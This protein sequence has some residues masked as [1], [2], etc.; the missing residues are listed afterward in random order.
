MRADGIVL[1]VELTIT[2]ADVEGRTLFTGVLRDLTESRK[3][4]AALRESER[5]FRTLVEQLP[6]VTY[7]CAFD[8]QASIRYIS[9]LIE[10]WTGRSVDD[11]TGDPEI[12]HRMVHPAD[13]ERV[14]AEIERSH[15]DV[16]AFECEYRLICKDGREL[17]V[18]DC[19]QLVLGDDGAPT[20][21]QGIMVDVSAL[22]SAEAALRDTEQQLQ[23]TVSAAPLTL[24]AF[25]LDGVM[26]L[27]TGKG[28]EGLGATRAEL[29]GHSVF[30]V[31]HDV[32]QV[33]ADC[34][35][36]L[37]GES[38]SSLVEIDDHDFACAYEPVFDDRGTLKSVIVVATDVTEQRRDEAQILHLAYHDQLT[39]LPNRA[40]FERAARARARRST[41]GSRCCTSSSTTS[42]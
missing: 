17:T 2:R 38:L 12:W 5:R 16:E 4:E 15:A 24:T 20:H 32:P 33:V 31:F 13:R 30:D 34:R 21:S 1:P 37:T 6:C 42:R 39:G 10:T 35:R 14:V 18:W 19:D 3:A 22:R 8:A 9:P 29:E 40:R 26:T 11:W 25:D 41:G 28:L 27:A 23:A 7:E 36:A